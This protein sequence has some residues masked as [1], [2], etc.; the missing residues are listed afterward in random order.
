MWG[1]GSGED[2]VGDG[3]FISLPGLYGFIVDG[4]GHRGLVEVIQHVIVLLYY[5]INPLIIIVIIIAIF[6]IIIVL[7][8]TK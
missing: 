3:L 1:W 6:N 8:D 5:P 7:T 2:E 4:E